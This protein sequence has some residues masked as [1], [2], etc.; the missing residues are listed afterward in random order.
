MICMNKDKI[1][2]TFVYCNTYLGATHISMFPTLSVKMTFGSGRVST[3]DVKS[4]LNKY[5]NF[6]KFIQMFLY[7]FT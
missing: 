7:P 3:S 1:F 2:L 4:D 6:H 5:R